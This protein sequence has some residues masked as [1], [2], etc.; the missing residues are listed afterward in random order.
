MIEESP[1]ASGIAPT[2]LHLSLEVTG[3][4][5]AITVT[6]REARGGMITEQHARISVGLPRPNLSSISGGVDEIVAL[7]VLEHTRDEERW[8]AALAEIA[9][10][11]AR[12]TLRVPRQG[13]LTWLDGLNAYRYVESVT[14]R[15]R[16]PRETRP[17]GWHRYYTETEIVA[18]VEH[19]G[20]RVDQV[21][22]AG[23][24][25]PEPPRLATLVLCDWLLDRSHAE[26]RARTVADRLTSLDRRIPAG[27]LSTH[28]VITAERV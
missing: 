6:R 12:L 11:G 10:P 25:L 15:G 9:S 1:T 20:F 3:R 23:A 16:R 19:A 8:L 28:M 14:G 26:R 17:T 21:E 4:I 24:N 18:L 5:P 2:A 22:R 27:P 13:P 7:D